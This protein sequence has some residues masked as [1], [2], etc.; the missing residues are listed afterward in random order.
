[1]NDYCKVSLN[2]IWDKRHIR[3]F[4]KTHT[5]LTPSNLGNG[6]LLKTLEGDIVFDLRGCD[7]KSSLGHLHPILAKT[8]NNEGTVTLKGRIEP[9]SW[10]DQISYLEINE[11]VLIESQEIEHVNTKQNPSTYILE[12][13]LDLFTTQDIFLTPSTPGKTRVWCSDY[14][15]FCFVEE[16][17]MTKSEDIRAVFISN[18]ISYQQNYIHPPKTGKNHHDFKIIDSLIQG[19]KYLTRIGRY[20]TTTNLPSEIELTELSRRIFNAGIMH[21]VCKNAL[22]FAFPYACL[23][24]EIEQVLS[25]VKN[26]LKD[27]H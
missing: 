21:S 20:V 6:M 4:S 9:F 2:Q 10:I 22:Y 16:E 1:M 27:S 3:K 23:S 5:N 12:R 17:S 14:F 25:I 7:K 11:K 19:E 8:D 24:S 15:Q 18:L 26:E 13:N